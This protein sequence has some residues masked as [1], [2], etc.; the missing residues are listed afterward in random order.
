MPSFRLI[1]YG[2]GMTRLNALAPLVETLPN[3]A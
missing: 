1:P 2:A 3:S